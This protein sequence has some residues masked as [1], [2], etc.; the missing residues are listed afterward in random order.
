MALY[1]KKIPILSY[2]LAK[3]RKKSIENRHFNRFFQDLEPIV[4]FTIPIYDPV[5]FLLIFFSNFHFEILASPQL[6]NH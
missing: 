2:E 6:R 5:D 4:Y 1:N 3:I